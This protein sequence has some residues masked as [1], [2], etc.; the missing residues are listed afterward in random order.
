MIHFN[1]SRSCPFG[2]VI[3]S[4]ACLL[5]ECIGVYPCTE[6]ILGDLPL[7]MTD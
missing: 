6:L 4:D 7:I 1:P 2:T 5:W 3:L